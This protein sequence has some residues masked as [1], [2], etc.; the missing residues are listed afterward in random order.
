MKIKLFILMTIILTTGFFSF[1]DLDG[2]TTAIVSS[3]ASLRKVPM[4]W[5]NRDTGTLSNKIIYVKEVPYSYIGIVNA[6]ETS[7]R[8]VY[9]G[10]NSEGFGIINTV[11][12][13]LPKVSDEMHD[14]EGQIMA[15][16][17]RTCSRVDDFEN[18]I[19]KNL[20]DTLGS[21]A[22]FGVIDAYGGSKIFEV[23]NNGYKKLDTIKSPDK[24]FVNTNFSRTGKKGK[25]AGYLRF[26]RAVKLFEKIPVKGITHEYIFQNISRDFGHTLVKHPTVN[27]L[28]E[29]P[30]NDPLW[31]HSS[32][33]ISRPS[34][35]GVVII[36][37]KQP[38]KKD[39]VATLWA[40]LGEPVTSIAVPVWVEAG[41]VPLP[42]YEG[43]TA[44]I[45]SEALRIKKIIHP[46]T[47][48][49]KKDYMNVTKLVNKDGKG[50]LPELLKTEKYIFKATAKFLKKKHTAEEYAAFQNKMAETALKT[51]K[52]IE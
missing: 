12:Y 19:K 50:F 6:D 47:E 46:F 13:N 24:Y 16:A 27:E 39:S 21:W 2:C 10:L 40:I 22:N 28:K 45:C 43:K 38:D 35:S 5:K 41:K 25:G 8:F 51:L 20:G 29:F 31:I 11:A 7:G 52:K 23:H 33:C 3:D 17:L 37:G 49:A 42:L 1:K 34:T 14:L 9:A 26:E 15:E 36:N 30:S 18:Y 48:G 32:N 4:L 44:P